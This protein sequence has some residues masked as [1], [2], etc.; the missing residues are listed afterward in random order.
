MP[1]P[2]RNEHVVDVASFRRKDLM[3]VRW[4]DGDV[5]LYLPSDAAKMRGHHGSSI[6]GIEAGLEAGEKTRWISIIGTQPEGG[7]RWWRV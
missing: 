7:F 6:D 1:T 5:L 4:E 3:L 2:P